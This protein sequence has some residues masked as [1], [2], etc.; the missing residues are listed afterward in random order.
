M[1][2]V[3]SATRQ[4]SHGA[5][6]EQE[7]SAERQG[8]SSHESGREA[9]SGIALVS[10]PAKSNRRSNGTHKTSSRRLAPAEKG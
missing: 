10:K 1:T 2:Q 3:A 7:T 9:V 6:A 8:C 4:G 5:N